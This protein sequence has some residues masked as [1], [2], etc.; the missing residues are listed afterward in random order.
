MTLDEQTYT[1]H[2]QLLINLKTQLKYL[3]KKYI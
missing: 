2:E 1:I 3:N